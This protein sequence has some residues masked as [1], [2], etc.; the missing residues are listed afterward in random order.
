MDFLIVFLMVGYPAVIV[1][2]CVLA[3]NAYSKGYEDGARDGQA[4]PYRTGY[5]TS[6]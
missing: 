6:R 3:S 1:L 2:F 4:H 5:S